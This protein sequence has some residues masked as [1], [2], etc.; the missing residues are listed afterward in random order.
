MSYSEGLMEGNWE[1]IG[2]SELNWRNKA[3]CK[4]ANTARDYGEKVQ[5][6]K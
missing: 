2:P 6:K 3:K 1:N 4:E 5:E